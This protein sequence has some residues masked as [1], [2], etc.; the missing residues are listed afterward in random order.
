MLRFLLSSLLNVPR[1]KQESPHWVGYGVD[2]RGAVEINCMAVLL[3][4]FSESA[5]LGFEFPYVVLVLA[6]SVINALGF[7]DASGRCT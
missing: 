2:Y 4:V 5:A 3:T 7:T 1:L 6:D